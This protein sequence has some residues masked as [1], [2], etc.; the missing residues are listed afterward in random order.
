MQN[1]QKVCTAPPPTSFSRLWSSE[2][3]MTSP[4]RPFPH[5]CLLSHVHC[6]S[7]VG[8]VA[9]KGS[10]KNLSQS[11]SGS[12]GQIVGRDCKQS[13]PV[14]YQGSVSKSLH[15][16]ESRVQVCE[17]VWAVLIQSPAETKFKDPILR[18]LWRH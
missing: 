13:R 8:R 10:L 14:L 4:S 3:P 16:M 15:H 2:F 18:I 12:R 17:D 7:V 6:C 5:S 11:Q 1:N 9:R